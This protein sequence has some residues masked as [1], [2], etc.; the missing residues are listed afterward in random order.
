MRV[1]SGAPVPFWLSIKNK[2]PAKGIFS[3]PSLGTV[4]VVG[5]VIL[6]A[7]AVFFVTAYPKIENEYYK[8]AQA[9]ER[10]LLRGT[11]EDLAHGQRMS[12]D[13]THNTHP[14]EGDHS[15][16]EDTSEQGRTPVHK[17]DYS[18]DQF[19]DDVEIIELNHTR[20]DHIPN[21]ARFKEL[22]ELVLRTN[23]LKSI[24][25]NLQVLTTLTEL[26]LY[27]NQIEHIENLQTLVNLKKL[28]LSFNRIREINGLSTLTKLTHIYLVH[29]KITEI[30]GLD[31][32]LE[33]ELLELG[34]NRIKKIENIFHLVKLRELYLGKNKIAKIEGLETLKELRL[35]SLPANRLTKVENLETLGNLEDLY[36]SDQG[37]EDITHLAVLKNLRTVDVSNNNLASFDGVSELRE[38]N[39][40]WANDNRISSWAEVE[41]LRGLEKLDTVYL[42]RNPIYE[43]DRTGYRRKVMLALEQVKQID[44]TMCR[45][46]EQL[47]TTMRWLVLISALLYFA[48]ADRILVLVECMS[49]RE[50]HS[51]FF[52]G[53]Q[54]RGHH[55][56]FRTADD[57]SL[58]LMKYGELNYD[59]LI[60]FA[61]SVDEF[62]GSISVEE[63]TRFVDEGGNLLVTGGPNLGQ[64]V[65]ELA[66][67]HGFEFD[68]PDTMVI[69]HNNYDTY[70]D[71]GYHTTIVATKEQL[72]NAHLIIG[73]TARLNP[74]LYKGV[75]MISHKNNLLRL[76]VLR[77]TTTSY[78][79]NPTSPIDEYPGAIG[80]Q[81][82]MIG[83]VQAR[84]NARAVFTGSM[85][86]FSDAFLTAYVHKSGSEDPAARSGNMKLVTALS[87]WVLKEN[88][89][90]RVKKVEHH[91]A[92]NREVPREYTILDEVEYAIEIEELKEGKWQ[93]FSAKDVQLEFVRIDPF[94]R[95]TLKNN[96]GRFSTRFKLPDV[97]GVY[98]FLVDYRRIGYTHLYDVQQVSVRPLLHDQYERFIRS[99]YPYYAS[100]FSMMA[101]VVLFSLVFL[102]YKEPAK[103][104]ITGSKKTN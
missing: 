52:R 16:K 35:L 31:S 99:A 95:T 43:S 56:V 13:D 30:K 33:L 48:Q 17:N 67:Q 62:G 80:K 53:L 12:D 40:F 21:L 76:E 65:R 55:L 18:L 71:D 23:L 64:A 74:V 11:R 51:I 57:P 89:V 91:L 81:V 32:L 28:D 93:P 61:P 72:L 69:D 5:T 87:K 15:D 90:L 82:I 77:G 27:E 83:A 29:N 103:V 34:D 63:I 59:H 70:L 49:A 3:R 84:N 38:L 60:I 50:T 4:A 6:T 2:I 88:G 47:R 85:E 75:A 94:V 22:K 45:F 102:Y 25:P 37:I 96:N 73:E 68:E 7:T 66:I 92:G 46:F 100:S 42:E 44:A 78:S 98:K 101:G 104:A 36:L 86:M 1:P 39:D 79:F 97:Y 14:S 20:A 41:K 8:D 26:D 24:G 9:K 19:A 58:S 54:E 10:A